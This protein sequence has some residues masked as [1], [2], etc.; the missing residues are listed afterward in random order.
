M[1]SE[2]SQSPCS[3]KVLI[4]SIAQVFSPTV[5]AQDFDGSTMILHAHPHFE[6]AVGQE[7]L[8]LCHKKICCGE[9]GSIVCKCDEVLLS[10]LSGHCGWPPHVSMD[11][12]TKLLGLHTNVK[13]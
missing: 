5:G 13:L 4:K 12:I 6:L 9:V 10:T 1:D 7:G 3:S 2:S 8:T 11:L